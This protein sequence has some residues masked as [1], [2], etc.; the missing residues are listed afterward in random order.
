MTTDN[1]LIE[2]REELKR[3]LASGEYKTLVDV[4]L[5]WFER[6]FQKIIRRSDP[7]PLWLS[8]ATLSLSLALINFVTV[9]ITSD[10]A[11]LLKYF[12]MLKL[13]YKLGILWIIFN[14]T[15]AVSGLILIN[16]RIKQILVFWGEN[17]L[18][19]IEST[20][21]F[22]EFTIW[23]KQ[24]CNWKLHVLIMIVGG[25]F[26]GSYLVS[27]ISTTLGIFIGYGFTAMIIIIFMFYPAAL[28]QF[29]IIILLSKGLGKYSLKLFAADPSSSEIISRLSKELGFVIYIVAL[30][31]A[32]F[33]L[34]T[35]LTGGFRRPIVGFIEVLLVWLP[36]IMMFI[37]NQTSLANIIRR[38]KWKTLNEVQAKIEKLRASKSFGTPKTMD[39]ISKLIDYHDR[40]K[41]T[42]NSAIES[43]TIFNFINS[44]LL[45]LLAFLLG[46]LDKVLPLL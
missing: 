46:N 7:I 25:V 19:L 8:T 41:A 18:D 31:A 10:W 5:A 17:V 13:T 3:Q 12:T 39:T 20:A 4:L 43:S 33:G 32:I 22:D 36:L 23:L 11:N 45:P 44:L 37:L 34:I 14:S 35:A 29:W 15:M 42:H 38:A 6:T 2:K 16:Q 30:Y 40:V 1:A 26:I 27:I 24:V 21:N 28:Y 9:Y